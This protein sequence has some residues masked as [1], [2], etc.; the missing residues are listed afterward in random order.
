MHDENMEF[1]INP[2]VAYLLVVTIVT[3]LSLTILAN[4]FTLGST[5]RVLRL[6]RFWLTYQELET[7][8]KNKN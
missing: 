7:L 4:K 6:D 5:V 2:S 1:L 3:V 8:T